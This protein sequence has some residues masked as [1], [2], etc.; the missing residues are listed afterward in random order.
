[1]R[2]GDELLGLAASFLAQGTRRLVASV[3]PVPDAET[4]E[5]M[6]AFHRELAR[7][8]S[9]AAALATAQTGLT[10]ASPAATAAAAGFV[11]VGAGLA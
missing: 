10:G 4:A 5:L 6:V 1:V 11:C 9:A 8:R 2:R 7:G 3:V